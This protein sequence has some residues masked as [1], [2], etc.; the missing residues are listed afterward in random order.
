MACDHIEHAVLPAE[1]L[2]TEYFVTFPAALASESPHVVKIVALEEGHRP[3]IRAAGQ[4][5]DD[6]RTPRTL[7]LELKNVTQDFRVK[8]TKPILVAHLMQSQASVP[9]G[10]W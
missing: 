7:P 10:F 4:C 9:S 6:P 3:G 5:A 1:T 2:G 8:S